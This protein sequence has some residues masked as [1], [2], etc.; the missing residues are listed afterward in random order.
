MEVTAQK[1]GV[2]VLGSIVHEQTR[3]KL[4][5][6]WWLKLQVQA[7]TMFAKRTK[8]QAGEFAV[9]PAGLF[10]DRVLYVSFQDYRWLHIG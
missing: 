1:K 9:L 2:T 8:K 7:S 10:R 4:T 6:H 3:L 5:L